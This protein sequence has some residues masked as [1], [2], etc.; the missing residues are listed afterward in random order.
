MRRARGPKSEAS[1][2]RCDF[3]LVSEA[4]RAKGR[5][6]GNEGRAGT[7][8]SKFG[9]VS[10][11]LSLP[12]SCGVLQLLPITRDHRFDGFYLTSTFVGE[13]RE[14]PF[15]RSF[16]FGIQTKVFA[17]ARQNNLEKQTRLLRR[18]SS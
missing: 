2:G 8:T 14:R 3:S 1:F 17:L 7:P 12:C 4:K 13:A 11:S 5:A 9:T 10:L 16:A 18:R 6:R 15:D